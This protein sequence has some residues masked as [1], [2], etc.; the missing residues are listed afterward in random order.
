MRA[1]FETITVARHDDHI[2]LVTLNR[3]AASNALNTRM[4]LDLVEVFETFSIDLAGLRAVIITGSGDKAFC[5]G[6]DLKERNG[7]TDA[8][9]QS[10]HLIFERMARALMACPV[11]LIAAVNGAAYGG[12][13]E[14]AAAADFVY[15]ASHARFALTE[16]TLGIMPGA[17]GT[18][19]LA[20]AV[21]ERRAKELIL[22]GLP[23]SAA[24]A[25]AW[26]LVNR[27]VEPADLLEA[28]MTTARRIA[29]NGPIAVRQAKQ[30]IH[31]GLQMSVSDGM[32]FEIEAYNRLVPTADRREGVLAFNEKR[33]PVFRGE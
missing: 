16:V 3:P 31:R 22:S 25:E 20:R 28:T 29:A 9:W 12:G 17:G 33:R 30:A 23:F 8:E 24:E 19:N 6:G 4:G 26:G 2:L 14:I 1:D 13:C 7:M 11:P 15:A 32:A 10:Q 21:G 5:A 27:V 18:Q